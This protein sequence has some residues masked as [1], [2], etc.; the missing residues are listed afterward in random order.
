MSAQQITIAATEAEQRLDRWFRRHFPAVTH[1]RLAKLL[2]TGQVRVDGK[3]V[4]ANTRV[5]PGQVIRV[6]PGIETPPPERPH[7]VP[8]GDVK[9]I[10]S[11]V[12]YEDKDMIA[13]NKPAGLAVQGGSGTPRHIDGMLAALNPGGEKPRLVHRLDRDTSGVLVVAKTGQAAAAMAG[14]FAHK[15]ARKIYVALV[16]GT[17][18]P[19]QGRIDMAIAKHGESVERMEPDDEGKPAATLYDTL[20]AAEGHATVLALL[21]LSGR[22]HQ[23]RVHCARALGTPILGDVKYGAED[24]L[25]DIAGKGLHLHALSL[26]I[27]KPSGRGTVTL[28]A[29]LPAHMLKTWKYFGFDANPMADTFPR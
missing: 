23:L 8:P 6:P 22:T 29:P 1:G 5:V 10:R 27:P 21:P 18:K 11:L 19:F 2:R 25:G 3:R 4:E 7:V 15:Q 13:L 16:L 14:A 24:R 12:I 26:E 17:P 20:E 28:R 9:L